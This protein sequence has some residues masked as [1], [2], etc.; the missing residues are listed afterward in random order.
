MAASFGTL[1]FVR[2][3]ETD[4]NM[5]GRLQGSRD[6]P[7]NDHGRVQAGEIAQRLRDAAITPETLPFHVSPLVRTRETAD[8]LR[9]RLGMPVHGYTLEPRLAELSF[10]KW[11]GMTWKEVR[12][13]DPSAPKRIKRGWH[14]TPP[15]GESYA[16]LAER[17]CPWLD[18]LTGDN[19][20]VSHG[21]VAR[22]LI[23]MVC[24]VPSEDA[25][26]EDIWQG[27]LLVLR[28]D[29]FHWL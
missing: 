15:E 10:G 12:A 6:I 28:K 4:W 24:G 27:R 26:Q 9:H 20:V 2:H 23:A 5:Q 21:G 13:H 22:A 17:L 16:M 3:G 29:G 25:T 19:V 11:E 1:Y 8:I 18:T 7:L 14:Y